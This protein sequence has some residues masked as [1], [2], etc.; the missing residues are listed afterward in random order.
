MRIRALGLLVALLVVA[1]GCDWGQLGFDAGHTGSQPL[2]RTIGP[3]NVAGLTQ[4]WSAQIAARETPISPAVVGGIVYMLRLL[5]SFIADP[6]HPP[7]SQ[8]EQREYLLRWVAP[9]IAPIRTTVAT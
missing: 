6:G 5:Q 8:T 3:A 9:A 7:R 2:E 4:R 1:T